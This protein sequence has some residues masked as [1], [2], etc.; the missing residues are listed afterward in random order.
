MFIS[1]HNMMD[2]YIVHEYNHM[3]VS[4]ALIELAISA[5]GQ[6]KNCQSGVG[7]YFYPEL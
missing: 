5:M 6:C 7:L 3:D 1:I 2:A 4:L